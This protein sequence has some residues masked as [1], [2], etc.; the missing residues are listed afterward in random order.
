MATVVI[1]ST[2]TCGYCKLAKAFFNEHNIAYTE[3]D[4]AVDE[5]ARDEMIAK[6]N[7]MGVPV[8]LVDDAVVIGF[9]KGKLSQLLGIS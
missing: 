1:Y 3:K 7:Q 6:T 4:V 9:D 8:I 2:P 5:A